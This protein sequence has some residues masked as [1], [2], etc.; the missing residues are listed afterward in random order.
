MRYHPHVGGFFPLDVNHIITADR[1][2]TEVEIPHADLN[3]IDHWVEF[4]DVTDSA[5]VLDD[6]YKTNDNIEKDF[7]WGDFDKDGDTDLVVENR[8]LQCL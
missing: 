3:Q 5:L 4:V 6:L 8:W 1:F 2:Q 7:E